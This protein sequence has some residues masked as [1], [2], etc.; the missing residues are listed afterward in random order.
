MLQVDL[1]TSNLLENNAQINFIQDVMHHDNMSETQS[2]AGRELTYIS[3][4][5][6]IEDKHKPVTVH[7]IIVVG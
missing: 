1:E 4:I 6:Y 3:S 7:N 5:G 2:M